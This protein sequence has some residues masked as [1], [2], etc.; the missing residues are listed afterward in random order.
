MEK[1]YVVNI[2]LDKQ[3]KFFFKGEPNNWNGNEDCA[4]YMNTIHMIN[5]NNCNVERCLLCVLKQGQIFH[6]Q[7]L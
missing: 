4:E 6:L 1:R 2:F 7:G 5:D 3:R